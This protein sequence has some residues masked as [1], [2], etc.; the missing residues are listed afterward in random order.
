[1]NMAS[2][3]RKVKVGGDFASRQKGKKKQGLRTRLNVQKYTGL[4]T[5]PRRLR[6]A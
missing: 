1:M 5:N 6:A 4:P 3:F 2:Q